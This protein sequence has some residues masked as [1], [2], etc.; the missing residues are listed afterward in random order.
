MPGKADLVYIEDIL[1]NWKTYRLPTI[2]RGF[3]W[4]AQRIKEFFE[5]I[6]NGLPV[7]ALI[8]WTPESV[9]PNVPLVDSDNTEISN[10]YVLDG[11]Q[12]LTS[13][14]LAYNNWKI[15]RDGEKI[16]VKP[17]YYDPEKKELF[18]SS[19]KSAE[20]KGVNL[21]LILRAFALQDSTATQELMKNYSPCFHIFHKLQ[22]YYL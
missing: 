20:K 14:F 18:V 11:Q 13:L 2:Q 10:T 5:S 8:L 12:R 15:T 19:S 6:I 4:N 7:G 9:F 17:I 16:T 1:Q 22:V 3:V 21:S